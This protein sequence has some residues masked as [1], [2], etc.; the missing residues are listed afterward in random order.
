MTTLGLDHVSLVVSD[1]DHSLAFYHGLLKIPILGRGEEEDGGAAAV[2]GLKS[3]HFQYADLD[4]GAGQI[5][6][7]LHFVRS[8]KAA[9]PHTR[10]AQ[11]GHFGL[12]VDDLELTLSRLRRS[13]FSPRTDPVVLDQPRWW[14]GATCVYVTDPDGATVELVERHR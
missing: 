4:L 11:S 5:L 10:T 1:I 2:L 8:K 9:R 6:E 3:V 14:R 12:R 7:L 13:G